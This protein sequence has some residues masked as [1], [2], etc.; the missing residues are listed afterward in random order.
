MSLY[1]AL[2][3]GDLSSYVNSEDT[4][5]RSSNPFDDPD[6]TAVDA[7]DQLTRTRE[8]AASYAA[9]I[10]AFRDPDSAA[11]VFTQTQTQELPSDSD[12]DG[13]TEYG[14]VRPPILLEEQNTAVLVGPDLLPGDG[15]DDPQYLGM[16]MQ[17]FILEA[18]VA[19]VHKPWNVPDNYVASSGSG[20]PGGQ[21][22]YYRWNSTVQPK[23]VDYTPAY[24]ASASFNSNETESRQILDQQSS[25]EQI[26]EP[27]TIA[28]VQI[29]NPYDRPLP[30]FGRDSNGVYNRN[31]P[32]YKVKLF[33][34][35]AV[36]DDDLTSVAGNNNTGHL[37]TM[38][39]AGYINLGSG[40]DVVA[41]SADRLPWFLPPATADAPYTLTMYI[42]SIA[43]KNE[44]AKWIDFLD[45][46]PGD[47]FFSPGFDTYAMDPNPS[48]HPSHPFLL[49]R[50]LDLDGE[51]DNVNEYMELRPGQLICEVTLDTSTGGWSDDRAEYDSGGSG[52]DVAVELIRVHR[53]DLADSALGGPDYS[54][55]PATYAGSDG[56]AHY[57][58]EYDVVIDR[59][60]NTGE[61][62]E[63]F[64]VVTERLPAERLPTLA[65][66]GQMTGA[67]EVTAAEQNLPTAGSTFT[68]DPEGVELTA[69]LRLRQ[70]A[71]GTSEYAGIIDAMSGQG[72]PGGSTRVE[73]FRIDVPQGLT[74]AGDDARWCQWARYTRAW[75]VDPEYPALDVAG[76]GIGGT[77]S[78]LNSTA[79]V[80]A[81]VNRMDHNAARYIIGQG[82]VTRSKG[83]VQLAGG[84][85]GPLAPNDMTT[86]TVYSGMEQVEGDFVGLGNVEIKMLN[87][88]PRSD[89]ANALAPRYMWEDGAGGQVGSFSTSWGNV[90]DVSTEPD[91]A[92]D[93]T[94]G[95]DPL[96]HWDSGQS[97]WMT[98]N[99][100]LP[101]KLQ[102]DSGFGGAYTKY[103]YANRKPTF[104]DMH[105]NIG[106]DSSG[107]VVAHQG[108]TPWDFAPYPHASIPVDYFP[109]L[110]DKG[111]YGYDGVAG[112]QPLSPYG[113]QMLQ[114]DANFEQVGEV[115]NVWVWGHRLKVPEGSPATHADS[116]LDGDDVRTFSEIMRG[117]AVA[118]EP[119]DD[120]NNITVDPGVTNKGFPTNLFPYDHPKINRLSLDAT[121]RNTD[122]ELMSDLTTGSYFAHDPIGWA[123][124]GVGFPYTAE[125]LSDIGHAEPNQLAAQR[126]IDLFVC[127]GPGI[128][129]IYNASADQEGQDGV[130]DIVEA[131]R[132]LGSSTVGAKPWDPSFGNAGRFEGRATPG[133]LNVNT[134]TV[135]ALRT[136]PHMYKMVHG[137]P[138]SDS[139]SGSIIESTA[140]SS[141]ASMFDPH[142]RVAIPEAI[143][144]YRNRQGALALTGV[145]QRTLLTGHRRGP[146]YY[147][148]G[149]NGERG[150]RG[151]ASLGELFNV[152]KSAYEDFGYATFDSG[153]LDP[154]GD[155]Y[156]MR[157]PSGTELPSESWTMSYAGTDP[158]TYRRQPLMRLR[159]ST[160]DGNGPMAFDMR[161]PDPSAIGYDSDNDGVDDWQL[162]PMGAP[163]STDVN[164][165]PFYGFYG[166]NGFQLAAST[167][168]DLSNQH[169]FDVDEVLRGGDKVAGDAE[170]MN[171]LFAGMSNMITTRSDMF[172]VHFRVRTFKQNP[173]TGVW[174]ATD[175]DQIVDDSRY[176]MLVDRSNVDTPDDS[177]RILYL[178][179]VEN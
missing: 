41:D 25:A 138:D 142:P 35:E 83:R 27:D 130:V 26:Q 34:K 151:I 123:E 169:P 113:L 111:Y 53:R 81:P 86:D 46:H 163:L 42:T 132:F 126:V 66:L 24:E 134:A 146:A 136:L 85:N 78:T 170:E 117:L 164:G 131:N 70:D 147:D 69:R 45:I 73:E 63:F 40:A 18:F 144:Q 14:A 89:P 166:S 140:N 176:V 87:P 47:H 76:F 90:F 155:R 71:L 20:G 107:N 141:A 36:I 10:L 171:L 105:S 13:I 162:L 121:Q 145:Y 92:Y 95:V 174:D 103:F 158:F 12:Y 168:P 2:T 58:Y 93:T 124:Q 55:V 16:E 82:Q 43:D 59:S 104:F 54:V 143:V 33:G 30:L 15:N 99:Y 31:L 5:D 1:I 94:I 72:G 21:L 125:W 156:T 127:D 8:M 106:L 3:S 77:V 38:R 167:L 68:T 61:G 137:T 51:I 109:R 112:A 64:D 120:V 149:F 118:N 4:P 57:D 101:A 114:K 160:S 173:D 110:P 23:F 52:N 116:V 74:A 97:P 67:V 102:S 153:D 11:P 108:A 56:R 157:E 139:G 96:V 37:T 119:F 133:L 150:Q 9:N 44:K 135:E 98:R 179:K 172:T 62:D 22:K 6:P 128:R 80:P 17:P 65:E 152:N 177:P 100:R 129:D 29:A 7:L 91:G 165:E 50:D 79:V 115:L 48:L 19:H 148:R 84:V 75:G 32:L 178:Q 49:S 159:A 154:S 175:R 88:D 122:G 60:G 161:V 28:V 39:R